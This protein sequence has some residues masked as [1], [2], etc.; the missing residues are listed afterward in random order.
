VVKKRDKSAAQTLATQARVVTAAAETSGDVLAQDHLYSA[1][2]TLDRLARAEARKASTQADPVLDLT[3][4]ATD[5]EVR[6]A[7]QR[8]AV[9]R[10]LDIFLPS[11]TEATV[12]LPNALL[13]SALF[14]ASAVSPG[15]LNNA[16]IASQGDTTLT[17]TGEGLTSYDR[18]CFAVCLDHYR[19]GRPLSPGGDAT[20]VR[21]TYYA[22][23]AALGLQY[24]PGVHRAIRAS[25]LRLNGANLRVRVRRLNVPLPRL[26][27]VA[28]DE[29]YMD[30]ATPD[31][32][33][34]GSDLV[35]FR[36][37]EAM[38]A[39]FGPED[40]TA[41]PKALLTDT[42]G[43]AS[44]LSAFYATHRDPY[45]L[46]L[47]DLYTRSGVTCTRAEFRRILRTAL[48]KL[49]ARTDRATRVDRY[50]V[51]RDSIWVC[52]ARWGHKEACPLELDEDI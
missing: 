49:Q 38:A 40:W 35:V 4:E 22:F 52:L 24:G 23:A 39:L 16:K 9:R 29:E 5:Q 18:K 26:V 14:A 31:E 20:W 15:F 19:E 43:L 47:N 41:V 1:A 12:G 46:P 21:T 7:R 28:F 25:L 44:W 51:T 13:R 48:A 10:G 42:A 34:L 17:M 2:D 33:L 3:A 30:G 8:R 6:A 37:T 36:V 11:W 50:A 27:E 45:V 32:D